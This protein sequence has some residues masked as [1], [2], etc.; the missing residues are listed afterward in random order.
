MT[1]AERNAANQNVFREVNERVV[2]VHRAMDV[3]DTPDR[4]LEIFC[5]CGRSHCTER[6]EL[7]RA[8]YER[9][10]ADATHFVLAC[11]HETTL[12]EHVVART[13]RYVVVENEGRAAE[14]ARESDPRA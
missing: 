12:V 6:L 10:R 14:L 13:E 4:L 1:G 2:E 3:S 9:V 7:T 11:G 8:E 5:E